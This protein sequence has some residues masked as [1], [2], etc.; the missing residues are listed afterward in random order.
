MGDSCH[1]VHL[2]LAQTR[3]AYI[4]SGS[5]NQDYGQSIKS[6]DHNIFC[7]SDGTLFWCSIS[8]H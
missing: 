6:K 5:Q 3:R 1:G 7:S 2:P 4:P 8:G